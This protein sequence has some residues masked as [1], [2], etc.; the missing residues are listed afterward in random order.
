MLWMM[1]TQWVTW[2][3]GR[4][5]AMVFMEASPSLP[6]SLWHLSETPWGW[7]ALGLAQGAVSLFHVNMGL[8]RGRRLALCS[9]LSLS[10]TLLLCAL[11][12]SQFLAPFPLLSPSAPAR[13]SLSPP[14]LPDV[15][16][17]AP[18]VCL[19]FF[20]LLCSSLTY[21]FLPAFLFPQI[22]VTSPLSCVL[23]KGACQVLSAWGASPATGRR[24]QGGHIQIA[25]PP[26]WL[27]PWPW[28]SVG[29][30][31]HGVTWGAGLQTQHWPLCRG[32]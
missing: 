5:L 23:L 21:F 22:L 2:G 27:S 25:P 29:F 9:F 4:V 16:S 19:S 26:H 11:P 12:S 6:K 13:S 17:L 24:L 7:I 18:G 3:R 28:C 15:C 10:L 32:P 1:D 20:S 31:P 30:S 8:M 14:T